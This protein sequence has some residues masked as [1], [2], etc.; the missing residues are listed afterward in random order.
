MVEK[1]NRNVAK[2]V[3]EDVAERSFLVSDDRIFLKFHLEDGRIIA[4]T[5][6]FIKP[7]NFSYDK[8]SQ[9]Q[10]SPDMSNS[11]QVRLV[12]INEKEMRCRKCHGQ[13]IT[14]EC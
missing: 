2:S 13:L 4:S 9:L 10:Y 7:P 12:P 11:F 14:I 1:F 6:E 5:R 3:D 8:T